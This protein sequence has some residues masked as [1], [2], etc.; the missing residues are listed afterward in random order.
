[1]CLSIVSE[2]RGEINIDNEE[3]IGYKVFN[4]DENGEL[5]P[6]F[7]RTHMIHPLGTWIQNKYKVDILAEDGSF[8]ISGFHVFTELVGAKLWLGKLSYTEYRIIK[9]VKYKGVLAT[10]KQIAGRMYQQV[11]VAQ[12]IFIIDEWI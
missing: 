2:R 8:Y 6:E 5:Y 11:D 3:K 1:M 9:R 12:E 10:G 4:I 7:F